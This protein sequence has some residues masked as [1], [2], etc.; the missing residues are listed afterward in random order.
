MPKI[1][2][3][4]NRF[5]LGG[6]T[7]NVAYLSR[8]F[9]PEY[10]T[11]LIGGDKEE[12]EDSSTFILE[13]LGI[14]PL[15][16]PELKR[17]PDFRTD[18]EAYKK[19]KN[20][21]KDFK[22]DIVHTHASKAG[23]VGRL[24][25]AS[26]KVPVIVHTFHGHVFHSYFGKAKT[27][28]YKNVERYLSKRSDA[29]VAISD[30]QKH[31][32][33]NIHKIAPAD[34]VHV[35]NLGFDLSRFRERQHEKRVAFRDHYQLDDDEIAIVIVGRMAPVKNHG[36]F[37]RC[38]KHVLEKTTQK[39]RA[40]IV[41]DGETRLATE[42]L[43]RELKI[44]FTNYPEQQL[45]KPLTFTSWI[46]DVDRVLAGCDIVCLTSLN[47]GTPVSLI[48]AQAGGR[49]VVSTNVGG[50]QDIVSPLSSFLSEINDESSFSFHLLN[51]IE[52]RKLRIE[53][54]EKG[55]DFVNTRFHYSRLVD[56]T[57][58]LY[59]NLLFQKAGVL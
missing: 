59:E 53:M 5:N 20:I 43:A 11:L 17:D 39:V 25:A 13:N 57:R 56:D 1:L 6:P 9:P 40:F 4:I 7:Y 36:M 23:A 55:W 51:L 46:N 41:G 34:K 27:T 18:R 38:L 32:L 37:L 10:E 58:K 49:P 45:K 16:L 26:C 35:I 42:A 15:I 24:A 14:K 8:Y 44:E 22:P 52:N 33:V 48:E 12:G 21:I 2:R 50:I 47:E 19:I 3:I 28:L 54:G 30:I 29:I 31:E